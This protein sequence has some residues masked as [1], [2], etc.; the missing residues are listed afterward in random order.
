MRFGLATTTNAGSAIPGTAN[1]FTWGLHSPNERHGRIDLRAAGVQAFDVEEG[2]IVI[3]AINAFRGWSTPETQEFDVLIDSDGDGAPDF[4]VFSIDNGVL[5]GGALNGEIDVAIF[6]LHTGALTSDFVANASTDSSTI[7]LAVLASSI[8]ITPANP[9]F[10]Y[11]A[12]A[13][14]LLSTDSDSFA[15]SAR[16][17]AFHSAVNDAQFNTVSPGASVLFP[18]VIDTAELALTPARGVMVISE[19]N[20]NGA[21]EAQLLALPAE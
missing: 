6:N 14:D 4:D 2:R 17:N 16:Y 19:D 15:G 12:S 1:L 20:K 3:F 11:T 5:N 10:R 9:R 18:I 13:F 7:R 21:A 8:G